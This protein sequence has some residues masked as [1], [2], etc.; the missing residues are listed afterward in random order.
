MC[1]FLGS[2]AIAR[3]WDRGTFE[4]LCATNASAL[5]IVL[6]KVIVYYVLALMT[7]FVILS[8]G[9]VLYDIPIRGNILYLL[10]SLSVYALEMIC[11]GLLISAKLKNQFTATQIAV[12]IGFLPT[13]MLSGLIFEHIIPPTYEV[14]AMRI[15]IMSGGQ[16]LYL[17]K[18][19]LIQIAWT[20]V[21]FT[22]T[23]RQVK[24]DGK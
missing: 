13:V 12:V 20:I 8:L 6:A 24:K 1:V 4:S 19:L 23:V 14:K 15:N 9:Q 5:D 21:F 18:N 17:L 7:M 22:L 11:L 3:E 16:E 10:V 2:F